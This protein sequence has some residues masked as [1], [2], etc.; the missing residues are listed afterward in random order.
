MRSISE[1]RF[2]ESRTR[3]VHKHPR[4][5]KTASVLERGTSPERFLAVNDDKTVVADAAD[6]LG[7]LAAL[8]GE[9]LEI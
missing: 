3:R 6:S 1:G 4:E 9:S 8:L 2:G 7:K 5:G